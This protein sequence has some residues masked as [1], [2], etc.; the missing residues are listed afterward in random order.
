[1]VIKPFIKRM[2]IISFNVPKTTKEVVRVQVDKLPYFYDKLHEHP[3]IQI[4]LIIKGEGTLIAGDYIGRFKSNDLFILGNHQPHVFRSDKNYYTRKIG[5]QSISLYFDKSYMGHQ[6]WELIEMKSLVKS[7]EKLTGG[8][9]VTGKTHA[10][11][12]GL[13]YSISSA[14]NIDKVILFLELLKTISLSKELK[15]LG[16]SHQSESYNPT[17]SKRMN[18]ILHFT[19]TQ[20]H[21]K[22]YINEVASKANLTPEAFC[23]YFKLRTRKT[24][25]R[26]L[27]EVRISNACKLLQT[28]EA[29]VQVVCYEVGFN[30][31]SHFNRIFKSV[32]GKTPKNYLSD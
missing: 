27:N 31:L 25:T 9:L 30:N 15:S 23:R 1:M 22:I 4:T 17:E 6:F 24:F 12:S 32:T 2:K 14:K 5:V 10:K 3:E 13:L 26:F 19:F 20:S 29:N 11:I 8:F 21:R 16:V 18:E 28:K 7:V